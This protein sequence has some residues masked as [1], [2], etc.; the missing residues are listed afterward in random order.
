MMIHFQ[1]AT[2]RYNSYTEESLNFNVLFDSLMVQ[3][4]YTF[5]KN[6]A[7][8]FGFQSFPRLVIVGIV[9]LL[10]DGPSQ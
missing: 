3:K 1:I 6:S 2:L 7:S 9:L 4:K 8:T 10:D 5:N